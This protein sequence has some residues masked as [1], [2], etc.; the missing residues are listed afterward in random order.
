MEVSRKFRILFWGS[1]LRGPIVSGLYNRCPLLL[2]APICGRRSIQGFLMEICKEIEV[3]N[4]SERTVVYKGPT[5]SFHA[6][7]P[8]CTSKSDPAVHCGLGLSH[9]RTQAFEANSFLSPESRSLRG[10]NLQQDVKQKNCWPRVDPVGRLFDSV[11]SP[12]IPYAL[13]LTYLPCQGPCELPRRNQP[14]T[15]NPHFPSKRKKTAPRPSTV[16][17]EARP[18]GTPGLAP[19]SRLGHNQ[20]RA[21]AISPQVPGLGPWA[22]VKLYYIYIHIVHIYIYVA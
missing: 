12:R 19:R 2:R 20:V 11:S 17:L 3:R 7:C 4:L 1:C 5:F 9:A 16:S 14:Q 15:L 10:Y 18:L 13:L 21:V 22:A 6:S 8:E